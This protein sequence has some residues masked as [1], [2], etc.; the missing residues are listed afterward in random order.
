MKHRSP[1][2][3][4]ASVVFLL[5]FV[6]CDD[7]TSGSADGGRDGT[8]PSADGSQLPA[9][10]AGLPDNYVPRDDAGQDS[11]QDA[12]PPNTATVVVTKGGLPDVGVT[13]VFEDAAGTLVGTAV[14]GADGKAT[15]TVAAGSQLT[16][17]LGAAGSRQLF[18]YVGVKPGDVINVAERVTRDVSITQTV[19]AFGGGDTIV[20]GNTS[21]STSALSTGGGDAGTTASITAT[22]EC[23]TGGTFPVLAQLNYMSTNYYSFKKGVAL[24]ASGTTNVSGLSPWAAGAAFTMNVTNAPA[25][26]NVSAV[27]GQIANNQSYA[28]SDNS[29][30]LNAG[31]GTASF[32]TATGYPDAF[33]GELQYTSFIAGGYQQTVT[34]AKRIAGGVSMQALDLGGGLLPG[35]TSTMTS[36]PG[37]RP[38]ITWTAAASLAAADSG[39]VTLAFLQPVDG[40]GNENIDW[41]FIVPPGTLT[42]TA[43]QLPAQLAAFQPSAASILDTPKVAFF[44]SD[45]IPSYDFVR[46]QAGAFGLA[47]VPLGAFSNVQSPA[48]PASGTL[49]I[50]AIAPGG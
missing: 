44:E 13:V 24:A 35:L 39:V 19:F 46:Q 10:D 21:C 40:G 36:Q 29:F 12:G 11:G 33:Q 42:V 49:R 48:L 41:T 28:T 6:A 22:P 18:T 45:L 25:G 30:T 26:S 8:V 3:F 17:A 5:P 32:T 16:V 2:V 9:G 34:F 7:D 37:A 38:V 1:L 27:L 20:V 47:R 4:V 43:P 23:I 14:T 31:A 15:S 50:T